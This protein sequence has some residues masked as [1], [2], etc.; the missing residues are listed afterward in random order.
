MFC[1]FGYF[2]RILDD[3]EIKAFGDRLADAIRTRPSF[4]T[5]ICF[6]TDWHVVV[7]HSHSNMLP[8]RFLKLFRRS[9]L[10]PYKAQFFGGN[11]KG[12]LAM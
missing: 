8:Q 12:F 1:D 5:K 6:G 11:L 10:A 2:D 4:A 3:N 7:V 9:D